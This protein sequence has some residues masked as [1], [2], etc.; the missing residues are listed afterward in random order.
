[1]RI[2]GMFTALMQMSFDAALDGN[3]E[4]LALCRLLEGRTIALV[5]S[6]FDAALYLRPHAGGIELFNHWRGDADV[7]VRGSL[8]ALMFANLRR[9]PG[10]PAGIHIAGDAAIGQQF[11]KLLRLLDIDWEDKLSRFVGGTAAHRISHTARN[12]FDW[13]RQGAERVGEN[14]R[15][16]LQHE[17]RDLPLRSEVDAF[18]AH[19]DAVRSDVD[20]TE[21]RLQR[22]FRR[23]SQHGIAK[24]QGQ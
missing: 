19:V 2:P 15:E 3:D 16:Y 18:N 8:P 4:A 1:L 5:F 7:T 21:A 11:Q 20:R 17:T 22:L 13:S 9:E 10:A 24:D 23:A 12:L 14:L 6:E